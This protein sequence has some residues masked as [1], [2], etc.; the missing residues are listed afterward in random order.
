MGACRSQYVLLLS[1]L[2]LFPYS[3]EDVEE[4]L[5]VI[6]RMSERSTFHLVS[7]NR[8]EEKTIAATGGGNHVQ[9]PEKGLV[10]GNT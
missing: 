2:S 7:L 4:Q 9:R 3:G 8:L 5:A 6:I 10:S 1:L